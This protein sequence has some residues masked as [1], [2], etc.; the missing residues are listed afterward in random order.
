MDSFALIE[1]Y[2]EDKYLPSY[3]IYA[4][5]Q[6]QVFH[7]LFAVDAKEN[8]VRVVTVYRPDIKKWHKDLK[9]RRNR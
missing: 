5:H 4:V 2:Q 6:N 8:N 9:T 7:I 1:S 3:L